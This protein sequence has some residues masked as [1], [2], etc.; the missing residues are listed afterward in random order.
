[1]AIMILT[2]DDCQIL[3]TGIRSV[4]DENDDLE[5]V[6]EANDGPE[7]VRKAKELD[8]DVVIM[9]INM[10]QIGGIEATRQ[11]TGS[12]CK[13]H[14]L[15]LSSYLNE[16]LILDIL[17][18]GASG[19]VTKDCISDELIRAVRAVHCGQR[20][21]CDRATDILVET[22][23]KG[24]L[25]QESA[26]TIETLTGKECQMVK[27]VASGLSGKQIAHKLGIS[28]KTV[29]GRRRKIREK[30]NLNSVADVV[31]FAIKKKLVQLDTEPDPFAFPQ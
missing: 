19:Y 27:M 21:L 13:T 14:V 12:G 17:E 7:A 16:S 1:M 18:A 3:R 5:I 23:T 2:V 6:G 22:V 8:P 15:A 9:D 25:P 11:I 29:D 4:V 28:I 26:N 24:K 20:Y 30:L 10:P 31:R